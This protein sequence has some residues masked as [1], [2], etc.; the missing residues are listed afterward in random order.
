[1]F[2]AF[3]FSTIDDRPQMYES[4][5]PTSKE[6]F[7][8]SWRNG[9][10]KTLLTW[11]GESMKLNCT[12]P[13]SKDRPCLWYVCSLHYCHIKRW[14]W[15]AQCLSFGSCCW[16]HNVCVFHRIVKMRQK[17][18]CEIS[19]CCDFDCHLQS[20]G[21]KSMLST[22]MCLQKCNSFGGWLLF[23]SLLWKWFYWGRGIA[24]ASLLKGIRRGEGRGRGKFK[25][26]KKKKCSPSI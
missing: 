17:S 21:C 3:H 8:S 25:T 5:E 4:D 13:L 23:W 24:S 7:Q 6:V 9:L 18:A 1:M 16:C 2:G 20:C 10:W 14:K 12:M 19:K 22:V 15:V 11:F 26:R